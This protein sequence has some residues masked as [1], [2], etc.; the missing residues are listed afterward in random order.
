MASLHAKTQWSEGELAVQSLLRVPP[1]P[2][3]TA[4]GLPI[5]Y[6]GRVQAAP[7]VAVGAVDAAAQPW[8]SIWAGEP[9]FVRAIAPA[10]VGM[11]S[12]VDKANDPV[13][14]VL[15]GD[16]ADGEVYSDPD[17]VGGGRP[18]SALAIDLETR[19]RVK[20][21]GRLVA[22][23]RSAGAADQVGDVQLA[24]AVAES[25][26][27]CPKYLNKKRIWMHVP[28]PELVS[29]ALPLPAR[30]LEILERADMF[31]MSTS[32][33][34]GN[35]DT[36]HRGGP[37][38]LLR[39]VSN[40]ERHDAGV[41]LAYPEFSGNRLYSSLGNLHVNDKVGVTIP[42]F[43]TGDVVYLTGTARL[44]VGDDAA[45]LL[46]RTKVA[47]RIEV[48][49]AKVVRDGLPFRGE[50]GE[51]SPYNPPVRRLAT[52]MAAGLG[53]AESKGGGS[54]GVA[55]AVLKQRQVLSPTITRYTFA[56]Q[57]PTG[58]P[59]GRVGSWTA[60]QHA[61]L[62]FS[63]ELD[64]GYSHMRDDDPQSLNDDFVR[65]F[66]V[67][68]LPPESS[69]GEGGARNG[70]M[71]ITVRTNGPVTRLLRNWNLRAPLEIPVMGFGGGSLRIP[72][73]AAAAG[74]DDA[75]RPTVFV[76]TGVG[77]TPLLSQAGALLSAQQRS[78]RA[79]LSVLWSLRREDV[80]FAADEFKRTPGLGAV[81]KLYVSD[82]GA[83]AEGGSGSQPETAREKG[84]S[85]IIAGRL[86]KQGLLDAAG[87]QDGGL[88][89]RFYIC[90][91]PAATKTI[92]EWLAGQDVVTESFNY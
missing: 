32:D 45:R 34:R 75:A 42:D 58:S 40:G 49:A 60:A 72:A 88:K 87:H 77:I 78:A 67:S 62:D 28:E 9:G 44:L 3:P 37:P 29:D 17:A 38:G 51:F 15:F 46:P 41:V 10:V 11:R 84:A 85:Q 36:N 24:M 73:A 20:L 39:V 71:Q 22:G 69:S 43:E 13:A 23:V 55:V 70:E 35:M 81:T 14:G 89:A 54:E 80:P 83:A 8:S 5:H 25:I 74:D 66:T 86:T 91:G 76:A 33:G 30:A 2:N 65:T 53:V 52:E 18:M 57:P 92:T 6:I 1:Q 12:L 50:A 59:K 21:A 68:N 4:D 64:A 90:A 63:S 61:T 79:P 16:L 19:D 47:V 56:L 31:F 27:N 82:L 26:G 48:T 7:L